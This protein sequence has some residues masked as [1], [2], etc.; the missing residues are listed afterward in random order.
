MAEFIRNLLTDRSFKVK[1]N[2]STSDL[3]HQVYGIQQGS[4]ISPIFF[5]LKI[6]GIIARIKDRK[7]QSFLCMDD[8]L[9]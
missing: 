4:L 1:V 3:K 5:I 9:I 7:I 6:N 8:L 2:N